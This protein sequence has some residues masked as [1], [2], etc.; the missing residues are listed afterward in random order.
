MFKNFSN[1]QNVLPPAKN[2]FT[3]THIH[4]PKNTTQLHFVVFFFGGGGGEGKIV[5]RFR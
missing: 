4:L 2:Q 5:Y 3:S 1:V